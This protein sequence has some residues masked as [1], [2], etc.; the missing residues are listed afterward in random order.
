VVVTQ[1]LALITDKNRIK[2]LT[3]YLKEILSPYIEDSSI[4]SYDIDSIKGI[5]AEEAFDRKDILIE[6][7]DFIIDKYQYCYRFGSKLGQIRSH[8]LLSL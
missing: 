5:T 4:V 3:S 6:N 7:I 2:S 8:S 1:K